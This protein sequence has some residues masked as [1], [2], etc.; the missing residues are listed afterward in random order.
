MLLSVTGC[1]S[2]GLGEK[3]TYVQESSET[4]S[5]I[6]NLETRV[7]ILEQAVLN[8]PSAATITAPARP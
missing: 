8:G 1:L 5:R 7:G 2:L 4:A 6:S 3:T